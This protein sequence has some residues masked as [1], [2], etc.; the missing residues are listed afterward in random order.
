LLI[1][2][3]GVKHV[4]AGDVID[5]STDRAAAVAYQTQVK[6]RHEGL[7]RVA[8]YLYFRVFA[9]KPKKRARKPVGRPSPPRSLFAFG[10]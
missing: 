10:A 9:S 5:L 4:K 3:R 6:W 2:K 7:A 1:T 8:R